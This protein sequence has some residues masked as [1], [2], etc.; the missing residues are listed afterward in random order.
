[1]ASD[2]TNRIIMSAAFPGRATGVPISEK[3]FF[4]LTQDY[5]KAGATSRTTNPVAAGH[6]ARNYPGASITSSVE[7]FGIFTVG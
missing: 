6:I 5:V 3:V 7:P 1:M 2:G 4:L